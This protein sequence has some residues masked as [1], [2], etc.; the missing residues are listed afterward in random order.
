MLRLPL[1]G[2]IV[3]STGSEPLEVY[4]KLSV[5]RDVQTARL[6][7]SV[8]KASS[9][10]SQIQTPLALRLGD[11]SYAFQT[12]PVSG[13]HTREVG[14]SVDVQQGV[15]VI[16]IGVYGG[17]NLSRRGAVEIARTGFRKLSRACDS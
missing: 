5:Y 16:Q 2:E 6:T 11:S 10:G 15:T 8:L 17:W 13:Q 1:Q 7:L 14:F 12:R 4:E 9:D 3:S